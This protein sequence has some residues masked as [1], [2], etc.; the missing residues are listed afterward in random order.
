MSEW[1]PIESAPKDGTKILLYYQDR[2]RVVCGHW[3]WDGYAKK[4]RPYWTS[5]NEQL[6]GRYFHRETSP[7]HWMPLPEPPK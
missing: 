1:Q 7:T 3:Y 2:S 5:D 6:W 4:P